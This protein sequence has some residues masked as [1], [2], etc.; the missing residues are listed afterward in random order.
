MNPSGLTLM[1]SLLYTEHIKVFYNFDNISL[2]YAFNL[3]LSLYLALLKNTN[4]IK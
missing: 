1:I 2:S 3:F 4:K